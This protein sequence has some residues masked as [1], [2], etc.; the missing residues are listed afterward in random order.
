MRL[1]ARR[2]HGDDCNEMSCEW[3]YCRRHRNVYRTCQTSTGECSVCL[4]PASLF[5]MLEKATHHK[6]I[7]KP[8]LV[9]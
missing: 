6:R 4:Q 3:A 5:F 9:A 7:L 8:G 2:W 1:T